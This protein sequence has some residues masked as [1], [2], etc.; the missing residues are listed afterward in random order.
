MN[1]FFLIGIYETEKYYI[2][3]VSNHLFKTKKIIDTET[4]FN[5]YWKYLLIKIIFLFSCIPVFNKWCENILR[6]IDCNYNRIYLERFCNNCIKKDI[7][8]NI[9]IADIITDPDRNIQRL[10]LNT[11]TVMINDISISGLDYD[12]RIFVKTSI[13]QHI[14]N[15]SVDITLADLQQI[16]L[17][18]FI[19]DINLEIQRTN[20]LTGQIETSEYSFDEYFQIPLSKFLLY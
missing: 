15:A 5:L 17:D 13:I 8:Q 16:N 11:D 10:S 1:Q 6:F 4:G 2:N 12:K 7:I 14:V 3:K 20:L 9:S 19:G 18:S